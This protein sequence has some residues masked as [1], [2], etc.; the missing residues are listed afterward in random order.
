M[1]WSSVQDTKIKMYGIFQ[2]GSKSKNFHLSYIK[3][4]LAIILVLPPFLEIFSLEPF[5]V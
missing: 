1:K 4:S 3:C 2:N 5:S